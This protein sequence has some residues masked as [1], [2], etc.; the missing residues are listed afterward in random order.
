MSEDGVFRKFKSIFHLQSSRY[1]NNRFVT[2]SDIRASN[3]I[4]HVLQG[5]LK[6][7]PPRQEVSDVI[8]TQ[9]LL[10]V[11]KKK[12]IVLIKS[13]TGILIF[14]LFDIWLCWGWF[15]RCMR[16][17]RQGWELEWCCS[18]FWWQESSLLDITSTPTTLNPSSSTTSRSEHLVVFSWSVCQI[19]CW[20]ICYVSVEHI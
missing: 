13:L 6:A 12:I 17:I 5:P 1:V 19:L 4:I 14:F 3:G 2:D 16:H 15:C 8:T 9:Y 20:N 18:L 10:I 11:D 7:P